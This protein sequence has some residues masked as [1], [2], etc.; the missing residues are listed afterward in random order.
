MANQLQA[1]V[2]YLVEA[3]RAGS[4]TD[5]ESAKSVIWVVYTVVRTACTLPFL[6]SADKYYCVWAAFERVAAGPD[7]KHDT[8]DDVLPAEVVSAIRTLLT[9]GDASV[10]KDLVQ[11]AFTAVEARAHAQTSTVTL[12][13]LLAIAVALLWL[14]LRP[15]PHPSALEPTNEL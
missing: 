15:S 8:A 11:M 5:T 12:V 10:M 1:R 9:T 6:S 4:R 3:L 2:D 14:W 7:G 13:G